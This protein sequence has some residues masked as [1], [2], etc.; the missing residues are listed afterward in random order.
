MAEV[1]ELTNFFSVI[2]SDRRIG[3]THISLYV[4]LFQFYNLNLLNN[5]IQI[6]TTAVMEVAKINRLATY[7]R[8]M[9][10]LLEYE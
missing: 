8:C 9:N 3:I 7:P 2:R 5:P 6:D 4:A 10:D 1:R